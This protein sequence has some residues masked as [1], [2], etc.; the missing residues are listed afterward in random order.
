MTSA[1][2]AALPKHASLESLEFPASD[3]WYTGGK[4]SQQYGVTHIVIRPFVLLSGSP[5][6]RHLDELG[7][8]RYPRLAR[9]ISPALDHQEAEV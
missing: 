1:D 7:H 8:G 3:D 9:S 4:A 6:L 2:R 5:R